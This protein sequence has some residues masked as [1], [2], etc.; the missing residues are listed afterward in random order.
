VN[1]HTLIAIAQILIA[2]ILIAQTLIGKP[3]GTSR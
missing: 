3:R 2:Q 1:F